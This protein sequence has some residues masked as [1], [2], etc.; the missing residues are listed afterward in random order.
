MNDKQKLHSNVELFLSC[1]EVTTALAYCP[2]LIAV[3]RMTRGNPYQSMSAT[4]PP[5]IL[6][7]IE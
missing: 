3:Y 5:F 6:S 2:V 1:T 4:L 7:H